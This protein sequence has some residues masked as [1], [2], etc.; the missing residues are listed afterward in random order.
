MPGECLVLFWIISSGK[1]PSVFM[2]YRDVSVLLQARP[3]RHACGVLQGQLFR[4]QCF[5]S[6]GPG[7]FSGRPGTQ[8]GP[9][10][11]DLA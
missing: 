9:P 4:H 10:F 8:G 3:D 6:V 1:S 5:V 7:L 11:L 2:Y